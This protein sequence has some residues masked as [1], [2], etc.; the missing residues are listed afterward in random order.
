MDGTAVLSGHLD[1]SMSRFFLDDGVHGTNQGKFALHSCIPVALSWGQHIVA[2]GSNGKI[3]FYN[4]E[5]AVIQEIDHSN[6]VVTLND[7]GAESDFTVSHVSPS[8]QSLIVG[9]YNR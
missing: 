2:A 5:G 6:D 1:G 4:M 3:T 7:T 9:S 8:G